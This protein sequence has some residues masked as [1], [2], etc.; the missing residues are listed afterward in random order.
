MILIDAL[1]PNMG[2]FVGVKGLGLMAM[3]CADYMIKC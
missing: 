1:R 2:S 3:L